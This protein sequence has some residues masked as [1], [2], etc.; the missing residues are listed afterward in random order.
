METNTRPLGIS[1]REKDRSLFLQDKATNVYETESIL[2]NGSLGIVSEEYNLD[3]IKL[4]LNDEDYYNQLVSLMKNRRIMKFNIQRSSINVRDKNTNLIKLMTI[5]GLQL[6]MDKNVFVNLIISLRNE[7]KLN[8]ISD[9]DNKIHTLSDLL[10]IDSI[11][12]FMPE[13]YSTEVDGDLIS[14][15]TEDIIKFIKSK[16][17][18]I[19]SNSTINGINSAKYVYAVNKFMEECKF[20]SNVMMDKNIREFVSGLKTDKYIDT[21]YINKLNTT[22][23]PVTTIGLH[24]ELT[25]Y[26]YSNIPE[27]YSDIE[28]AIYIYLKLTRIFHYD[29]EV[30]AESQTANVMNRHADLDRISTIT[31]SKN[32]DVVCYEINQIYA[33]V[34]AELGINYSVDYLLGKYGEGHAN[35]TFRAD[36]YVVLADSVRTILGSD[37]LNTK[38]NNDITG[39]QCLNTNEDTKNEFQNIL[40]KVYSDIQTIDPSP[41]DAEDS[42][43]MWS[44]LLSMFMEDPTCIKIKDKIDVFTSIVLKSELPLTEK[45]SYYTKIYNKLFTEN[46][47]SYMTI[48]RERD[49]KNFGRGSNFRRPTLIITY[50]DKHEITTIDDNKYLLLSNN[51]WHEYSLEELQPLFDSGVL[52]IMSDHPIPGI[53]KAKEEH[54]V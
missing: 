27:N 1:I 9:I 8:D 5:G 16:N 20:S 40:D 4:L 18:S 23:N 49:M 43:E 2:K 53:T 29:P 7:G 54:S 19:L 24:P 38:V 22:T 21:Y 30:Y 37:L 26:I 52:G 32:T 28:K 15:K 10:S 25:S 11:P 17:Y 48:I 34:L 46:K 33:Q 3:A 41:Y 50:N 36:R 14:L 51:E 39:L 47:M 12:S 13:N 45:I 31:P 6:A 35:L 44:E 42:F